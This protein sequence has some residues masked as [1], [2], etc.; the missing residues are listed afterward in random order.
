MREPESEFVRRA[1]RAAPLLLLLI[2]GVAFAGSLDNGFVTW[3]DD[4]YVVDT[5][6]ARHLDAGTAWEMV[7]S[8]HPHFQPLARLAHLLDLA[9]FGLWAGGHHLTSLLL[10]M[11]N[12]VLAA[13]LFR[14]LLERTGAAGSPAIHRLAATLAALLWAVH[15]LRVEAVVWASQKKELLATGFALLATLS[16]LEESSRAARIRTFVCF[17]LALLAKPSVVTLPAALLV[18]DLWPAA[19]LRSPQARREIAATLAALLVMG[20]VVAR[21]TWLGAGRSAR[22]D[23]PVA[24]E[25]TAPV[26]LSARS[27]LLALTT[28]AVPEVR[29][30]LQP[31]PSASERTVANPAYALALLVSCGLGC[32]LYLAARRGARAVPVAGLCF[33]LFLAPV[34]GVVPLAGIETAD[35]FTYLPTLPFYALAAAALALGLLRHPR[36]TTGLAVGVALF[37]VRQTRI[38]TEVWADS[39]T[40]W[41]AII[42]E[43]PAATPTAYR[44]LAVLDI[45]RHANHPDPRSLR[46][47]EELLRRARGLFPDHALTAF[48]LG[49]L[50]A[51]EGRTREA[52]PELEAACRLAPEQQG[53]CT[54]LAQLRR[55]PDLRVRL[56][57]Q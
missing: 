27:V 16:Y 41:G 34:S 20:A 42:R 56:R 43:H 21:V 2:V 36:L 1:A 19:R 10:H 29:S 51:S 49:M 9:L 24:R 22:R 17:G 52:L 18:L 8:V 46:E 40:F 7:R 55:N 54:A 47:A 14:R 45:R 44:N 48:D 31:M 5:P 13:L 6:A 11:G 25:G 37:L 12:A 4:T 15:P 28:T 32:G 35:R 39:G 50:L 3:D 30:P 38:Q 53:P 26:L 23:V 57:A 33:A